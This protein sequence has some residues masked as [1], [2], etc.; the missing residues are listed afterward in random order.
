LSDGEEFFPE[1]EIEKLPWDNSRK[2]LTM[3]ELKMKRTYSYDP[4]KAWREINDY[5]AIK[6]CNDNLWSKISEFVGKHLG[7]TN[8]LCLY[9]DRHSEIVRVVER[10]LCPKK[11]YFFPSKLHI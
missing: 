11:C 3:D 1:S 2:K 5:M 10:M 9:R 4:V 7:F 6:E 8:S